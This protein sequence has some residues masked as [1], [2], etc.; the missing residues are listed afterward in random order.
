MFALE[1]LIFFIYF[2]NSPEIFYTSPLIHI[3]LKC[4]DISDES[5]T[6][7]GKMVTRL[8]IRIVVPL[9]QLCSASKRDKKEVINEVSDALKEAVSDGRFAKEAKA[10][11]KGKINYNNT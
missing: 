2:Q 10:F 11:R 6:V 1:T 4:D 8:V 3:F 5:Q 9:F 7:G